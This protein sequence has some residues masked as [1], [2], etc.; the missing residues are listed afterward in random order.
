M[1]ILSFQARFF[2]ES[3]LLQREVKIRLDGVYFYVGLQSMFVAPLL[4]QTILRCFTHHILIARIIF[5]LGVSNANFLGTIIHPVS[6]DEN[7]FQT[8]QVR[9]FMQK[10]CDCRLAV[11]LSCY[12]VKD[13]L[14]VLTGVCQFCRQVM[15]CIEVRKG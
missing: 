9:L 7:I 2:T 1:D 11:Y 13:L 10:P 14:V 5:F 8:F 15:M 3:R 4:F 6:S 12:S